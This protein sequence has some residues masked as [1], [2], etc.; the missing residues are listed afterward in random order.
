WTR[1]VGDAPGAAVGVDDERRRRSVV[2]SSRRQDHSSSPASACIAPIRRQSLRNPAYQTGP[3]ATPRHTFPRFPI[4]TS[5]SGAQI[6]GG[7]ALPDPDVPLRS[8]N[9][10]ALAERPAA[11]AAVAPDA[12]RDDSGN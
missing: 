5:V 10:A 9:S 12:P 1:A 11:S 7:Q 2:E 8:S 3:P 4:P 6:R